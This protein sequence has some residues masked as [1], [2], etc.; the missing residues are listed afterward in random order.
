M[1]IARAARTIALTV[2]VCALTL[3]ATAPAATLDLHHESTAVGDLDGGDGIISSG[4]S[5]A[6]TETIRS[7]EPGAALTG[8]VGTLSTNTP[9]VTVPQPSA[10][11]P[12]LSFA[13]TAASLTPFGVQLDASLP[14]GQNV[15]LALAV[16][17]DQGTATIPFSI[18][19]GQ[20]A[21]PDMYSSADVPHGIPDANTLTST[22]SIANAARVKQIAVHIGRINHDYDGDLRISLIAPDGTR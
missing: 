2:M 16:S 1:A 17:A 18:G 10:A 5:L 19:T 6:V 4:D 22:L 3:P 20:A 7:G 13:D 21:A 15:N 12:T 8:I 9:N 14:C 11:F